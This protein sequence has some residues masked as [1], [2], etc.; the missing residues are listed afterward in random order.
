M[1]ITAEFVWFGDNYGVTT[2]HVFRALTDLLDICKDRDNI[3]FTLK[4]CE[5]FH[6]K[7]CPVYRFNIFPLTVHM[8]YVNF[9]IVT[10]AV[11]ICWLMALH[12]VPQLVCS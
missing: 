12:V 1:D 5:S 4:V 7:Q 8:H 11:V 9:G 10:S 6:W 2:L 3:E